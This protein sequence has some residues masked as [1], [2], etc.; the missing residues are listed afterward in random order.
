[1]TS[2][3]KVTSVVSDSV[4]PCGLQPSRLLSYGILQE[5]ILEW[6]ARTSSR[7]FSKLGIEPASFKSPALA[8]GFFTTSTIWEALFEQMTRVVYNF[9]YD[10]SYEGG[11][12]IN[13][14][15]VTGMSLDLSVFRPKLCPE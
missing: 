2:M 6:V 13:F 14:N 8:G 9:D 7:G 11:K 1:M 5:R 10:Q 3:C 4:W 12:C 15:T